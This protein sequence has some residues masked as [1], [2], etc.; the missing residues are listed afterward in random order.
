MPLL[1]WYR[2][3]PERSSDADGGLHVGLAE[4]GLHIVDTLLVRAGVVE[5]LVVG[6]ADRLLLVVAY[7]VAHK[8]AR[9]SDAR[10][11]A[12][13]GIVIILLLSPARDISIAIA[14]AVLTHGRGHGHRRSICNL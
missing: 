5:R 7:I 12:H 6:S 4:Q 1:R 3:R 8:L 14:L 13:V 10:S 11:P 2:F 9:A